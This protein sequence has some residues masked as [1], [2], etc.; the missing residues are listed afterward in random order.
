MLSNGFF[1]NM[2]ED[3]FTEDTVLSE[4]TAEVVKNPVLNSTM[5]KSDSDILFSASWQDVS[6]RG[7]GKETGPRND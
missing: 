2:A 5:P 6:W 3:L 1:R 7:R 4:G